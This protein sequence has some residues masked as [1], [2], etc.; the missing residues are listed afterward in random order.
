MY[1]LNKLFQWKAKTM[2]FQGKNSKC[3]SSK[4]G[5]VDTVLFTPKGLQV[6]T[7]ANNVYSLDNSQKSKGGR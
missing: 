2:S 7:N 6:T 5:S 1:K 4:F 3:K